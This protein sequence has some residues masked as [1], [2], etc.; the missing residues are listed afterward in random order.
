MK[1]RKM[2]VKT[3]AEK[4]AAAKI[5]VAKTGR[6]SFFDLASYNEHAGT[7]AGFSS[8]LNGLFENFARR[9]LSGSNP[10]PGGQLF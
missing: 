8:V 2:D 10:A 7:Y 1:I 4:A 5:F 3:T 9:I 6:Q